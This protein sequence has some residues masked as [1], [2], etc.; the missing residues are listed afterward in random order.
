MRLND[1]YI[2]ITGAGGGIGRATSEM[3]AKDGYNLIL[4][5]LDATKLNKVLVKLKGKNHIKIPCDLADK[6]QVQKFISEIKSK[7]I[8]ISCIINN[9]GFG[10]PFELIE[11]TS[12]ENLHK[13]FEINFFCAF[14]LCKNFLPTMKKQRFGRI[15][16]IASIQGIYAEKYSSA[17]ISS[18]HALIGLTKSI[19]TEYAEFGITANAIAP[20]YIDTSMGA[21]KKLDDYKKLVLKR[22][23]TKSVGN[24]D[25]VAKMVKFLLEDEGYINGSVLTLDGGITSSLGVL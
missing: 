12:E 11:N 25:S 7:K 3:L 15:I 23:P 20:G 13:V 14:N 22:T 9:A 6:K 8:K 1:G 4:T 21:T 5:D 17:Y 16:N 10:G 18:K 24:P 2:I 19:A